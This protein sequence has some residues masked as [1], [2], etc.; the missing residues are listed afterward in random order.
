MT[1]S[2]AITLVR[3]AIHNPTEPRHFM[4]IATPDHEVVATLDGVELARSRRTL[5]VKEVGRDIYDPVLYFPRADVNMQRLAKTA[6]T[7]HCPLK[8]DT[9]YFDGVLE[10]QRVSEVAWSYEHTIAEAA[11]LTD[12]VAFDTRLVRVIERTGG[13]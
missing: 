9:A 10:A 2:T 11:A 7:T 1:D 6:K 4:R 13:D 8:G 12:Y 5:K 3:D